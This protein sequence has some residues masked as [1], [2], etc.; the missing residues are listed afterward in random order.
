MTA[1]ACLP[2][3]IRTAEDTVA[4]REK[5]QRHLL[6]PPQ[7]QAP[8]SWNAEIE[9]MKEKM[10]RLERKQNERSHGSSSTSRPRVQVRSNS[11]II[12]EDPSRAESLQQPPALASGTPRISTSTQIAITST[13]SEQASSS[14]PGVR[15][16]TR[17]DTAPPRAGYTGPRAWRD[18]PV[19][20]WPETSEASIL[21]RPRIERP[22]MQAPAQV[23][24]P[25]ST[26]FAT[27]VPH[28]SARRVRLNS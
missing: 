12:G 16:S 17:L 2:H 20:T 27:T 21:V 18:P 28:R 4:Y 1:I 10:H 9:A 13:N 14:R 6:H 5:R 26:Q 3:N 25:P 23:V 7:T 11:P 15:N 22:T 24:R 8:S 19:P